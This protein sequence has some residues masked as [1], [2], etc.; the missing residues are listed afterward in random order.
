MSAHSGLS[1]ATVSDIVV[2]W[3][4]YHSLWADRALSLFLRGSEERLLREKSVESF[5]P[6]RGEKLHA[7]LRKRVATSSRRDLWKVHGQ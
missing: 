6:S 7:S 3:A 2:Q 1:T 5:S 4:N